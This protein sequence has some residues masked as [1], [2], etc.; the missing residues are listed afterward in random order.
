VLEHIE[1]D[2]RGVREIARVLKPGG[3]LL[4]A[5]PYT[6]YW[7]E[8]LKMM[9]HFRHYTRE[10]FTQLMEENGLKVEAYLRNYPHWHQAYTRKY[11]MVRAKGETF[12]R[13]LGKRGVFDF[14]WPWQSRPAIERVREKLEP[15]WQQDRGLDY[16][17]LGTS[18]FLMARKRG[19][20]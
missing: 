8:Y 11:S 3:F 7:P 4:A 9:G 6:Y 5:V 17:K 1:D 20:Q 13:V 14:K 19:A 12:G 2:A 10:S 16:S 18:T 15:L